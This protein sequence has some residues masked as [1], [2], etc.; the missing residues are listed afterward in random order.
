MIYNFEI[1]L[2]LY[3]SFALINSKAIRPIDSR[4]SVRSACPALRLV[5]YI[6]SWRFFQFY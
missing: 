6:V 2:K 3:D 4:S 1:L 5:T